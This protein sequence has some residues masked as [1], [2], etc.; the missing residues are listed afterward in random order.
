MDRF[1][2]FQ[3][4]HGENIDEFIRI[5][6]PQELGYRQPIFHW[7]PHYEILLIRRGNYRIESCE[8]IITDSKPRA[9]V[10]FPYSLHC[11]YAEPDCIYE[12]YMIT[13]NKQLLHMLAPTMMDMDAIRQASFIHTA[14]MP[15]EMEE[16]FGF[17]E[18]LSNY[19]NDPTMSALFTV[20][21]LRKIL[22]IC[23]EGHGEIVYGK[24][25][26]IQDVLQYMA[27]HLQNPQR[28]VD[29]AA[30]FG[31]SKTKFNIDFKATVGKTYKQHLTD[32]RMTYA[33]ELLS[34]GVSIINA[35]ID[36]GYANE[37][38]FIKAFREYWGITPG[39]YVRSLFKENQA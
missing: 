2:E 10:H 3:N 31:V 30:R 4:H 16:L 18:K 37:A 38:H 36:T 17:A 15:E 23:D 24:Y 35:S 1:L 12:R 26:Y 39:E 27:E 14:P 32:L 9:F 25:S 11:G 6:Y 22:M 7:H 13:F 21:I 29:L 8:R 20:I 33:H 34:S 19:Q 28:A 5:I